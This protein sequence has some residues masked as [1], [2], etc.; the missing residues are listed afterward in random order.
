MGRV[1]TDSP[2]VRAGKPDSGAL[3]GGETFEETRKRLGRR[4]GLNVPYEWW[5]RAASL[6]AIEA[7]GFQW[8]QVASPPVEMLADPRHVVRHGQ[9]LRRS[10]NVSSLRPI[11]HGPTNLR[12]G[13]SLHNRA[14]E[15]LLEWAHQIEASHVVYHA[16]EFPR[17]GTESEREERA[18]K[19]LARW[20]ETLDLVICLENLCPTYPG[21]ASVS[22]DPEA[23]RR[24]VLRCDS[25][26]ARML[27]DVGHANVVADREGSDLAALV[28]PVL[29]VVVLFH[30][31]DNLGARR[32]PRAWSTDRGGGSFDPLRLDLHLPPGEGALPWDQVATKLVNHAA[33]LMLEI[34]PSHRPTALALYELAE[35]TLMQCSP[36]LGPTPE[37]FP[38]P[39]F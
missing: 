37:L 9:A 35:A 16:L 26:A 3:E 12:L 5:P 8:V 31:H 24:L 14:F 10:L 15:G 28:E 4:L 29:D 11:V 21:P 1:L 7:A 6:K 39:L 13:S 38:R 33:P 30:V 23:V 17:L 19:S 2:Q 25:P 18:L 32:R 20:A 27:L 22:H 34:H 36:R